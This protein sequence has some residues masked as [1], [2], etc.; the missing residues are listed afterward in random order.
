MGDNQSGPGT[1]K[2]EE[3]GQ[4]SGTGNAGQGSFPAS[5]SREGGKPKPGVVLKVIAGLVIIIIVGGVTALL[6]LGVTVMSPDQNATYPYATTYT[7]SFPEGQPVTIG[8]SRI[9]VL[10]FENEMITD[11]D[12]NREKL[13]IGDERQVS[14]RRAR[15]TTLGAIP[16]I[17]TNFQITLKYKGVSGNLANFDMTIKTSSQVPDYLIQRILPP[18]INARPVQLAGN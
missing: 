1:G 5:P 7:V 8:N 14:G 6:T 18:G 11:I 13:A 2:D 10:S 3:Q 17:D 15:I 9:L 4:V 16:L 12:G